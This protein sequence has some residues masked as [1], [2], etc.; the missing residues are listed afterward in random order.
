M[1]NQRSS[2]GICVV[3]LGTA[4]SRTHVHR[5]SAEPFSNLGPGSGY[6]KAFLRLVQVQMLSVCEKNN[7]C[8]FLLPDVSLRLRPYR[9]VLLRLADSSRLYRIRETHSSSKW[10]QKLAPLHQRAHGPLDPSFSVRVSVRLCV[11]TGF[12]SSFFQIG[13]RCQ[14]RWTDGRKESVLHYGSSHRS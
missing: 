3:L 5:N 11:C 7:S 1:R 14:W 10:L 2:E 9:C 6:G 13:S 8:S 12:I 4:K